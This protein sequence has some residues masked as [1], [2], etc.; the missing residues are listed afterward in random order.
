LLYIQYSVE[1]SEEL[2]SIKWILI[3]TYICNLFISGVELCFFVKISK[4]ENQYPIS[5]SDMLVPMYTVFDHY[6]VPVLEKRKI[7]IV[8][9][10]RTNLRILSGKKM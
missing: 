9:K 1:A 5:S 3:N 8:R 6:L 4:S 10:C 7:V 2:R